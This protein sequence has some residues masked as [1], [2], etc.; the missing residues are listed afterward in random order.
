MIE[1]QRIRGKRGG[2]CGWLLPQVSLYV[3]KKRGAILYYV[4]LL[5]STIPP[6]TPGVMMSA[7]N[8]T[9]SLDGSRTQDD[10]FGRHEKRPPKVGP[11]PDGP[12]HIAAATNDVEALRTLLE[13]GAHNIEGRGNHDFTP[14]MCASRQGSTESAQLLLATGARIDSTDLHGSTALHRASY[15]G[16]RKVVAALIDAGADME[17]TDRYGRTPL[18]V[19]ADNGAIEAVRALLKRG[20]STYA[21]DGPLLDGD[22]PLMVAHAANEAATA[23]LLQVLRRSP[24]TDLGAQGTRDTP[25]GLGRAVSDSVSRF[26]ALLM[27]RRRRCAESNC[28]VGHRCWS[29]R[30]M[31]TSR[32]DDPERSR[33]GECRSHHSMVCCT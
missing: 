22:T 3:I 18:H 31:S 14:L 2:S 4:T 25:S 24:V 27:R 21:K 17:A 33:G 26:A 5:Y 8:R 20:A 10:N 9:L 32:F 23:D 28:R 15:S 16:S 12:L 7:G 11:Q 29:S 30:N 6:L 1:Y 19:A 13:S